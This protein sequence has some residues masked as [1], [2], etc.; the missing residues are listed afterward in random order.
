MS[1]VQLFLLPYGAALPRL[2]AAERLF[3]FGIKKKQKIPAENFSFKASEM[4]LSAETE[5]F[6]RL[7]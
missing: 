2:A 5:K 6:V 1:E 3:L 4:A 7:D